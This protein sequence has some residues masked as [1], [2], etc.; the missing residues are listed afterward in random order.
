MPGSQTTPGRLG[1]RNSAPHRFAF[2]PNNGVGTQKKVIFAAQ[3][4]AY[5]HPCQRFVTC[6]AAI[7]HA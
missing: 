7:P 2:R 4:L 1:T 6:L 3:W 5:A